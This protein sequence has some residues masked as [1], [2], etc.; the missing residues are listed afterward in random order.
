MINRRRFK[1][2]NTFSLTFSN[3]AEFRCLLVYNAR[4]QHN[5]KN[6]QHDIVIE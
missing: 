2:A 5:M 4:R 3:N 1:I 6:Q